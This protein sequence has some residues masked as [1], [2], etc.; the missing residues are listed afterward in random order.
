MPARVT[1]TAA[2]LTTLTAENEKSC[3]E[4]TNRGYNS[5][6][7]VSMAIAK[8]TAVCHCGNKAQTVHLNSLQ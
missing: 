6:R 2:N 7:T 1:T 4:D 8:T 3:N 5:I